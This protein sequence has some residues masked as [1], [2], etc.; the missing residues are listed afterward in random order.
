MTDEAIV[1]ELDRAS[2]GEHQRFLVG[3]GLD[4]EWGDYVRQLEELESGL[5]IPE[6]MVRGAFLVAEVDGKVVGRVSLRYELNAFLRDGPGHVGYQ[7]VPDARGKGYATEML[8]QSIALLRAQGIDEILASCDVANEA[9]AR[10]LEKCGGHH[11]ETGTSS[12]DGKPIKRFRFAET[13][14]RS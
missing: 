7:V 12:L 3:P 9:S 8:R 4:G 13:S 14:D 5:T 2:E 10:V 6:G 1:R 11:F